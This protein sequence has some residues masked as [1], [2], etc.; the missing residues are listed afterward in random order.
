MQQY[1]KTVD[2]DELI[3]IAMDARL[4]TE[5]HLKSFCH[6]EEMYDTYGF[7]YE[8]KFGIL[9]SAAVE[10]AQLTGFWLF[11]ALCPTNF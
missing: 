1:E 6:R 2:T 9:M 8:A 7:N 4:G 10:I 3:W 11:K 5:T